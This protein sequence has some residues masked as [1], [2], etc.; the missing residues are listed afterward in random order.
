MRRCARRARPCPD[1]APAPW[2]VV[3]RR[4]MAPKG[5]KRKGTV[6]PVRADEAT[7]PRNREGR[8]VHRRTPITPYLAANGHP[9]RDRG[10]ALARTAEPDR[11]WA[12]PTRVD[13]LEP[14][15]SLHAPPSRDL[16]GGR[17]R[18]P[19]CS[20]SSRLDVDGAMNPA[21]VMDAM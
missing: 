15:A 10:P 6:P 12:A 9:E 17:C 18:W 4:A 21:A 19:V 14:G 1:R 3:P 16:P 11:R 8:S 5:A 13:V 2:E 20:P 7:V